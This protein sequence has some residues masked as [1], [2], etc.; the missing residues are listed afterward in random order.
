MARTE[1]IPQGGA[2]T[3]FRPELVAQGFYRDPAATGKYYAGVAQQSFSEFAIKYGA[4]KS[5][6]SAKFIVSS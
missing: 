5:S 6:G 3:V 4:K 1:R 2:L